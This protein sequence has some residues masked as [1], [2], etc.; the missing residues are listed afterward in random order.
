MEQTAKPYQKQKDFV[1]THFVLSPTVV[2]ALFSNTLS[3]SHLS[4]IS[5]SIF[6]KKSNFAVPFRSW[7]IKLIKITIIPLTA[8]NESNTGRSHFKESWLVSCKWIEFYRLQQIHVKGRMEKLRYTCCTIK[9]D[10]IP[11][12]WSGFLPR[13]SLRLT[14]LADVSWFS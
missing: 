12:S 14:R 6:L 5:S 3:F 11:A 7:N 13:L 9:T 1:G 4:W 8:G 10:V 2:G